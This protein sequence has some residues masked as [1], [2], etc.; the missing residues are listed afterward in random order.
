[1]DEDKIRRIVQEEIQKSKRE[2]SSE[3][4]QDEVSR[5]DFLKKLGAGALGLGAMGF[6][7]VSALDIRG[8]DVNLRPSTGGETGVYSTLNL[9]NEDIIN[10]NQ[11]NG[12]DVDNLGGGVSDHSNLSNVQ[13]DQ[14]HSQN[15]GNEDHTTNYSAQGH[16]HSGDTIQPST[17]SG[18]ITSRS[19]GVTQIDANTYKGSTQPSNPVQ[20]DQWIDTNNQEYKIYDGSRWALVSDIVAI[21]DSVVENFEDGDITVPADN[22]T[23]WSGDTA[24]LTAQQT[25]VLEGNWSGEVV[26]N[27]VQ[28]FVTADRDTANQPTE[29]STLLR[30]EDSSTS[31]GDDGGIVRFSSSGTYIGAISLRGGA[32]EVNFSNTG[33]SYLNQTTYLVTFFNIDFSAETFDWEVEQV[34]D[35]TIISSGSGQSFANSTSNADRLRFDADGSGGTDV[36]LIFDDVRWVS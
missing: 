26:G 30:R 15:H 2:Q 17:I 20:G 3:D 23:G 9:N 24:A 10:V 8:G 14:H 29:V 7:G 1:M 4:Q 31:A 12:Q 19:G 36:D 34:S 32:V 6:T 16:S 13:S 18:S 28:N 27:G 21:P 11:I 35:N 33:D 22:W 25:T 5:R